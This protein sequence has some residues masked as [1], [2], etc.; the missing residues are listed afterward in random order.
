MRFRPDNVSPIPRY[1]TCNG[2]A[3]RSGCVLPLVQIREQELPTIASSARGM[4]IEE[5]AEQHRRMLWRLKSAILPRLGSWV[6]IP[7][8]APDFLKKMKRLRRS[9][10]AVFCFLGLACRAGEAWGKLREASCRGHTAA[11]GMGKAPNRRCTVTGTRGRLDAHPGQPP[12]GR[13]SCRRCF[14]A[15]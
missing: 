11:F 8:P 12:G 7:S 3:F 5:N 2:S 14:C 1:C 10:G 9:F 6:R 13:R 15:T 4:L